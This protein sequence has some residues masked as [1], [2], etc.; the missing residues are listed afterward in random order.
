L[1]VGAEFLKGTSNVQRDLMCIICGE[2]GQII[3]GDSEWEEM[4]LVNGGDFCWKE[5]GELNCNSRIQS[6]N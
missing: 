5:T 1:G 2:F 6:G 4:F 3:E